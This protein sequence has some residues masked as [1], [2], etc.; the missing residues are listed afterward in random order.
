MA[1]VHAPDL[2]REIWPIVGPFDSVS[3]RKVLMY[4]EANHRYA[5]P[6]RDGMLTRD[7]VEYFGTVHPLFASRTNSV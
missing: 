4:L 3:C 7:P 6:A 1:G 5:V 2:D